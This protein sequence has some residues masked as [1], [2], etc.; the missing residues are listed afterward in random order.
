MASPAALLEMRPP[1]ESSR[2]CQVLAAYGRTAS[3]SH[4]NVSTR[5]VHRVRHHNRR[6]LVQALQGSASNVCP[7]RTDTSLI[8]PSRSTTASSRTIPSIPRVFAVAGYA[9]SVNVIRWLA[10]CASTVNARGLEPRGHRILENGSFPTRVSPRSIPT[11]AT[12]TCCGGSGYN[13]KIQKGGR[14]S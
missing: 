11:H 1:L 14:S 7:V 3:S 13:C 5:F 8:A 9:G 10:L 4:A 12:A 2:D 6:H